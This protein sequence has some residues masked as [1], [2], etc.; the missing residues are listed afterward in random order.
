MAFMTTKY[1]CVSQ[2][3]NELQKL[4]F[5]W[6][7]Y[8]HI[9]L[10]DIKQYLWSLRRSLSSKYWIGIILCGICNSY[11]NDGFILMLCSVLLYVSQVSQFYIDFLIF[12]VSENSKV[13]WNLGYSNFL[14]NNFIS[15]WDYIVVLKF[16]G[17]SLSLPSLHT[18]VLM[19]FHYGFQSYAM[20][21]VFPN[22]LSDWKMILS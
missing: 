11:E 13:R 7:F 15:Y 2:E 14:S 17:S 18:D 4:F 20:C 22:F 3:K 8:K 19:S 5:P 16:H 1:V 6:L 9:V 10:Y 12:S 21:F